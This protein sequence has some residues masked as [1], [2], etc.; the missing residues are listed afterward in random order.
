M[1]VFLDFYSG[2]STEFVLDEVVGSGLFWSQKK[3]LL[4]ILT[5]LLSM[6]AKSSNQVLSLNSNDTVLLGD[7]FKNAIV[8]KVASIFFLE[9]SS[10]NLDF[11]MVR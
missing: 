7:F 9:A 8:F 2:F 6:V 10:V 4:E 3:S 11:V 5:V 1:R